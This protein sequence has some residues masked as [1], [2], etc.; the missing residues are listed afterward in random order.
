VIPPPFQY[1]PGAAFAI[2]AAVIGLIAGVAGRLGL[3]RPRPDRSIRDLTI[4]G[5]VAIGLILVMTWLAW[6]GYSKAIGATSYTPSGDNVVLVL[7][8]WIA[9]GI[10]VATIVGLAYLL[11]VRRDLTSAYVVVLGVGTGIL[12][13]LISAPIAAG[14]FGGV[15]ASGADFLVAAFR[16]AGADVANATLGQGLIS[17]PIDKVITFVVVYFLVG[18]M[19]RRTRARFPQ[20]ERLVESAGVE[21]V[22]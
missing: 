3:L 1:P 8:A 17:D 19:A 4:G 16:Q 11:A 6:Q 9:L 12:A 21:A 7:L 15:T 22:A 20:G 5:A 14:V 2:V 18:A 10:V 13:A